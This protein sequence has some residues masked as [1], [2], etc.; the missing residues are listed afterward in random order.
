MTFRRETETQKLQGENIQQKVKT[1]KEA[2]KKETNRKANLQSKT[3]INLNQ[4][5][6]LTRTRE[7]KRSENMKTTQ[8]TNE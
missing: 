8:R 5:Q 2:G 4:Y 6:C 3:G 1:I 7:H